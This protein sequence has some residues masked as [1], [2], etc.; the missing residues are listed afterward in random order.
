MFSSRCASSFNLQQ[1][2]EVKVSPESECVLVMLGCSVYFV[3]TW[4]SGCVCVCIYVKCHIVCVHVQGPSVRRFITPQQSRRSPP[5]QSAV[6]RKASRKTHREGCLSCWNWRQKRVNYFTNKKNN[7][8]KY[9]HTKR[10]RFLPR[11]SLGQVFCVSIYQMD[12]E[13]SWSCRTCRALH[14]YILVITALVHR[15]DFK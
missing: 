13:E 4:Y 8:H 6:S 7:W 14:T 12:G 15:K 11:V 1:V 2:R 3:Y 10:N 5:Q 9:R